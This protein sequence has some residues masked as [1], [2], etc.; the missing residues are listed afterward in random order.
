MSALIGA[1][2][3]TLDILL[4]GRIDNFVYRPVMPKVYH[5]GSRVLD[6]PA[7]DVDRNVVA[8]VETCGGHEADRIFRFVSGCFHV[9]LSFGRLSDIYEVIGMIFLIIIH[10]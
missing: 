4:D 10:I 1:D 7:H 3:D 5:L 9:V 8:V 6:D 2:S